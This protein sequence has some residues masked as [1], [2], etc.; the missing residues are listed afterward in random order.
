MKMKR[1]QGFS[2]LDLVIGMMPKGYLP[3][4]QLASTSG[5]KLVPQ[6]ARGHFH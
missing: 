5:Q 3:G 4:L 6:T 1:V 2:I